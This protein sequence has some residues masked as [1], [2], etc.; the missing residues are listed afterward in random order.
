MIQVLWQ[1][2]ESFLL[3][4]LYLKLVLFSFNFF[5]KLIHVDYF[6]LFFCSVIITGICSLLYWLLTILF[7]FFQGLNFLPCWLTLLLRFFM[8]LCWE[9]PITHDYFNRRIFGSSSIIQKSCRGWTPSSSLTFLHCCLLW[10]LLLLLLDFLSTISIF[11]SRS[12]CIFI[13]R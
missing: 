5:N 2:K 8:C 13:I 9:F 3:S 12:N 6:F 7:I 10:L 1:V 11:I 4:L